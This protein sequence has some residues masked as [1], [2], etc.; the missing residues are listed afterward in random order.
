[1]DTCTITHDATGIAISFGNG[2]VHRYANQAELAVALAYNMRQAS[3]YLEE[4][5]RLRQGIEE[6][7]KIAA[8]PHAEK[9]AVCLKLETLL[10]I[11]F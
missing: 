4:S 11:P 2:V 10:E 8:S 6:A 1:M 9:D 3:R 5:Q 7:R